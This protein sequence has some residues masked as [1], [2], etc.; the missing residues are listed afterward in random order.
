M[1]NKEFLKKTKKN[2]RILIVFIIFVLFIFIVTVFGKYITS[3]IHD[4]F[5][6]SKEFYFYS[7]KL[8]EEGANYQI[9]NW[10]GVDTYEIV[11][12]MNSR[13]NN[14]KFTSYDIE[15]DISYT[16][17]DNIICDISKT[18]GT[19][20]GSDNTDF[21]NV[22]ITPN[23]R[24]DTGDTVWVEIKA[25]SRG[26]YKKT[27]TGRFTLVV[28]KE[29]LSYEIEDSANSQYL[30]LKITNTLSY[31]T[32]AESF[33]SYRVGDRLTID[34]YL[35]LSDVNKGKCYSAR[36]NVNFDPR[37]VLIDITD[38]TYKDSTNSGTAKVNNYTYINK[39]SLK[40]DA[41]ESVKI[42]FYKT[43]VSQNYS[44]KGE[45]TPIITVAT[46]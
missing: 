11:V 38:G 9:E 6:R 45:G 17:S 4:F 41:I 2:K 26:P 37:D 35:T 3:S 31:Y 24:L 39:F 25:T 7:D 22:T 19:I 28:G 30:E 10:S 46:Y 34:D 8:K 44:Y 14:L 20:L 33:D 16:Y 42:R 13:R 21:F 27:I 29:N 1:S 15:Y 12:N 23:A 32:V 40:I 18:S 5:L 36:V 43:D